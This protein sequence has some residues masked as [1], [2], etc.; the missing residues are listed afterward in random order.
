M[1]AKTDI[2]LIFSAEG[3]PPG[4]RRIA[5][6]IIR[7]Y[8][9]NDRSFLPFDDME[10]ED[11][12][13]WIHYPPRY[14]EAESIGAF[15]I[16][17]NEYLSQ[18]NAECRGP[19]YPRHEEAEELLS[20]V[21]AEGNR[22]LIRDCACIEQTRLIENNY[23]E[24]F[25]SM[26]CLIIAAKMPTLVF[27]GTRRML[28]PGSYHKRVVTHVTCDSEKMTFEQMEGD[29]VY[30]DCII[31]WRREENRFVKECRSFPY[32]LVSI[33]TEDRDSV[34]Q[35]EELL[36]WVLEKNR[37]R[38]EMVAARLDFLH[39][40]PPA[41]TINAATEALC[42]RTRD[43]LLAFL[44]AKGYQASVFS[45]LQN[46]EFTGAHIVIPSYVTFIGEAAFRRRRSLESVVIPSG[47]TDIGQEAFQHCTSLTEI[48]LPDSVRHIESFAFSECTGLKKA[49]LPGNLK[50]I[51]EGLFSGCINL[52]SI[53]LPEGVRKIG[54][55]AFSGCTNLKSIVIP[56]T[57]WKFGEDVF[58]GCGPELT[59]RGQ[60]GSE[61]ESYAA[62]NRITFKTI[63]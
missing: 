37:I 50:T 13:G 40:C 9:R 4:V 62:L 11:A 45:R 53:I 33:E 59:I 39:A 32:V 8:F 28:E 19:D 18:D 54:R 60:K 38:K 47:V 63:A 14:V 46:K 61:A 29:P 7:V 48:I 34:K 3:V 25:F 43:E 20:R 12:D 10:K 49:I 31:T 1:G 26:L 24:D 15:R 55:A 17:L 30:A 21:S 27:E 2:E 56:E 42:V 52:E 36:E 41:V 22:L 16:L 58:S 51:R 35:D 44:S 57:V 23:F 6:A 5:A